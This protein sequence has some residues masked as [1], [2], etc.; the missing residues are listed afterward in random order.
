MIDT[1]SATLTAQE[2]N[3]MDIDSDN[4]IEFLEALEYSLVKQNSLSVP[5]WASKIG[6]ERLNRI[7]YVLGNHNLVKTNI[8]RKYADISATS[9]LVSLLDGVLDYRVSTKIHRYGMKLVTDMKP[10]NLVKTPS[11]IKPTGLVRDGFAYAANQKFK[12]DI[13]MLNNYYDAILSNVTKSIEKTMV[14]YSDIALDEANYRELCQIVLDNYIANPN[15]SYNLECNI[16]DQRGRAIY[17][18]IKRV[19]NPVSSKDCRALL[20]APYKVIEAID[21]KAR[22]DIYLFIAELNGSKATTR[23]AK[24]LAGM[25]CYS[26][27]DLPELDLGTEH[28]RKELHERIWLERIYNQL[29]TMFEK[30]KVKWNVPIEMDASMSLAQVIGA[31]LDSEEL[32]IKTNCVGD[33][34]QDP[35]HIDGT[36]RA[37]AKAV[38]TPTF[39]G[40][41]QSAIGLL[42]SKGITPDKDELKAINKEFSNGTFSQIKDFKNLLIKNGNI[43][44]PTYRVQGWNESYTVEVNKHKAVGATLNAH[45]VWD[46]ETSKDKIFFLHEPVR[47]PDYKAFNTF[48]ATG[49]VHNLDSKLMDNVMCDLMH[50]LE[51]AIAIHDAVLCLP[52]TITRTSYNT[53]LQELNLVGRDVLVDYM[54]SIGATS[55][56]ANIALAKLL[57]KVTKNSLEFKGNALK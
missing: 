28:D 15:N 5:F 49:L 35:W 33:K 32:L 24:M 13:D 46:T 6:A 11:G 36:R 23:S 17:N 20:I 47:V 52:G 50:A 16:S 4:T 41:S 40:S 55:T 8:K 37:S 29:D 25:L 19:F 7:L 26:R 54:K 27:R 18:G 34:L 12:L 14:E 42:K 1:I 57:D 9:K 21:D 30:G 45:V 3:Y 39:Y 22:A 38:G 43:D 56:K 53:H 48:F 2:L 31:V 10:A 44:T 51:W